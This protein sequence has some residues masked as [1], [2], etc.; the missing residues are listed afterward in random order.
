[1]IGGGKVIIYIDN[2]YKCHLSNDGYMTAVEVDFFEGKCDSF[3]EG[4]RFIPAGESWTREDGIVFHGEMIAPW[5]DYS[6]LDAIQ[7]DYER[8]LI[9][10]YSSA[11]SEIE[12]AIAAPGVY[13]TASTIVENRR[14]NIITRINEIIEILTAASAT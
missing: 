9:V 6:E 2:D 5:R 4:Y 13:G 14:Q 12:V 1:M 8:S 11:L 3:I 10:E 7:Y